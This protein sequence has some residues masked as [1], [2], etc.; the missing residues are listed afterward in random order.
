MN[1]DGRVIGV[2]GSARRRP[3]CF[4]RRFRAS[5]GLRDT[6]KTPSAKICFGSPPCRR[7]LFPMSWK[8]ARLHGQ[9]Q[10]DIFSHSP[11]SGRIHRHG[12]RGIFFLSGRTRQ[13]LRQRNSPGRKVL[14][15]AFRKRVKPSPERARKLRRPVFTIP[16]SAAVRRCSAPRQFRFLKLN[17]PIRQ[18]RIRK[19]WRLRSANFLRDAKA[20]L[21][22]EWGLCS[23]TLT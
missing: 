17:P 11:E 18:F 21:S 20:L 12:R 16:P 10:A 19:V 15:A 23:A 3:P 13:F 2:G 7:G 8:I 5:A 4:F 22:R 9:I 1:A 14:W 6:P